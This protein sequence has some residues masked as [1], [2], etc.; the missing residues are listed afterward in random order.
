[1]ESEI[2]V[3][4]MDPYIVIYLLL[5]LKAESSD[6]YLS[7]AFQSFFLCW[8]ILL[9]L[10]HRGRENNVK[11][12]KAKLGYRKIKTQF[13]RPRQTIPTTA[14]VCVVTPISSLNGKARPTTAVVYHESDVKSVH[15]QTDHLAYALCPFHLLP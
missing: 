10:V 2:I 15:L 7:R 5:S 8:I 12:L 6:F 4:Y 14:S 1:M 3:F 9:V 13:P 11:Y